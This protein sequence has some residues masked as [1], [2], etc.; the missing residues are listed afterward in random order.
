M[1]SLLSLAL[2]PNVSF[3]FLS[4]IFG[5]L[6]GAAEIIARYRDEPCE[7]TFSKPG[8]LYLALNGL[9]SAAAYLILSA[10]KTSILPGLAGDNFLTSVVAGFGSML[11]M[12]SKLFNFR[13]EGGEQYAVGPDAVL[14]TFL[15]SVDRRIDRDRS[16]KR[17]Q[18][19]YEEVNLIK[20]P[21]NKAHEFLRASLGSYQNLSEA[22]KKVLGDVI[23]KFQKEKVDPKI[24]LIA[25][26][27]SFLNISGEKNFKKLMNQLRTY[28]D[29]PT[30]SSASESST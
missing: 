20:N 8:I 16:V 3:L 1:N 25:L 27:F 7:A 15:T 6:V 21:S 9:I 29:S 12:R 13:T 11:I 26:C 24:G 28:T 2:T 22:E 23:V 14:S 4:I 19:V 17:Q 10:Y 30:D 18:L 5:V